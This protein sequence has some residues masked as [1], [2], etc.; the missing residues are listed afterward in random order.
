MILKNVDL[1]QVP[2]LINN[3]FK[4]TAVMKVQIS[5]NLFKGIINKNDTC[6]KFIN[7]LKMSIFLLGVVSNC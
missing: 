7:L 5:N 1:L 6:S 4:K 2:F 3:P